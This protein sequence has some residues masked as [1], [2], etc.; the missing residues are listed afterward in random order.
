MK[1]FRKKSI[2]WI[3][4][5]VVL[6][7]GL[8]F[9]VNY[10]R[11]ERQPL[12][13]AQAALESDAAVT[14]NQE[15]WLTFTPNGTA[16]NTGFIFYPGGRISYL[17]YADLMRSIAEEEYLV[18]VPKMPL[19]MAIFNTKAADGIISAHPE[20]ERWVIGGHSV[21]GTA[22]AIYA[23][24]HPGA[25]DG[26]AIWSS[27]PADSSD[28]S[29]AAIP[30]VLLYGSRETGV[31]DESVAAR[32]QLLPPDTTY[33]KIEGGDHHQFGSYVLTNEENLATT[34]RENQHKEILSAMFTLL[35]AVETRK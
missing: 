34:S 18:V 3:L 30:V 33:V 6:L 35:E 7:V 4:L 31:T 24:D 10:L 2:I 21:G 11:Y 1:S 26:L 27:F 23:A 16:P 8:F 12:P 5:G 29:D 20:I 25:V 28:L 22:A 13:Q 17:G 9:G 32:K 19:N 15:N 14:V